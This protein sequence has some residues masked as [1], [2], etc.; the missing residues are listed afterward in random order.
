MYFF[1][2]TSCELLST[3]APGRITVKVTINP[4]VRTNGPKIDSTGN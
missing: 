1:I 4:Y 3:T 2:Q